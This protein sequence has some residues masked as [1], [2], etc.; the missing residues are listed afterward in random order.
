MKDCELKLNQE[1]ALQDFNG[2]TGHFFSKNIQLCFH[3]QI[4]DVDK[5]VTL[6][7]CCPAGDV[8]V[9]PDNSATKLQIKGCNNRQS[10]RPD[11]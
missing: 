3:L 2:N 9:P 11:Y 1:A 5:M 6:W 7:I 4:N 8:S 10:S